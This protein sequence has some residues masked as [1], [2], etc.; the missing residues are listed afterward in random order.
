LNAEINSALS[1]DPVADEQ[2]ATI[3]QK[4]AE[5]DKSI[6][7]IGNDIDR[8]NSEQKPK[9]NKPLKKRKRKLTWCRT[10]LAKQ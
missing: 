9:A 5:I 4:T 6:H 1:L 10:M 7:I 8:N 3:A 2:L